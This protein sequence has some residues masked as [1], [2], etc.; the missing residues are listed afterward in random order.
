MYT[1]ESHSYP[2][3]GVP[4]LWQLQQ[5]KK[6]IKRQKTDGHV[7]I[8][9]MLELKQFCLPLKMPST[10]VE[11]SAGSVSAGNAGRLIHI[12]LDAG[13][14]KVEGAVFTGRQQIAW[15]GQLVERPKLF[16][17]HA[18]GKHKLHHGNVFRIPSDVFHT[19]PNAFVAYPAFRITYS[20]AYCVYPRR[21]R[22]VSVHR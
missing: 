18:D 5:K 4:L 13:A 8:T 17:L 20:I 22:V 16:V 11:L 19:Y 12:P 6:E 21:I 9:N 15:M 3:T 2:C 7:Q 14:Y 1:D 10:L